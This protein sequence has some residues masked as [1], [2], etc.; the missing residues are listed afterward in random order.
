VSTNRIKGA[1]K[2]VSGFAKEAAGKVVGDDRLRLEGAT[3]KTFGKAQNAVGKAQ[4][5]LGKALKR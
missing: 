1:A 5:S 3:E 2:Q 4:D